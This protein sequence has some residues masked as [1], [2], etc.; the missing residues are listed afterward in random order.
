MVNKKRIEQPIIIE[1][2]EKHKTHST[3][4]QQLETIRNTKYGKQKAN[5]KKQRIT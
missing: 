3:C 5:S 2:H 4:K 1:T